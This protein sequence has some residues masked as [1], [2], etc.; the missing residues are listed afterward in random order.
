MSALPAAGHSIPLVPSIP[1][2]EEDSVPSKAK[3]KAQAKTKAVRGKAPAPKGA[4]PARS[5]TARKPAVR[6]S[7]GAAP[8]RPDLHGEVVYPSPA[9]VA[10]AYI[11]DPDALYRK[12]D[13]DFT[14][15]WAECARELEWFSPWQ[16]V[17]EDS[18]KPF[19]KWFTGARFNIVHNALDR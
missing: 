6:A 14:G 3:P 13:K 18:A 19:Y 9:V 12:A 1:P 16:K 10:S 17:L 8:K 4:R 2:E 15:F 7:R 11:Q 5:A